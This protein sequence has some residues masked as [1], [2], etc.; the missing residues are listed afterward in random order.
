MTCQRCATSLYLQ[1]WEKIKK[2]SKE[3]S[4]KITKT[5]NSESPCAAS[6]GLNR[7]HLN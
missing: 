6:I 2:G 4:N 3:E 5:K 7:I 1:E